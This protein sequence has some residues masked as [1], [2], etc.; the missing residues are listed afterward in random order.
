MEREHFFTCTN[1][2]GSS[3]FGGGKGLPSSPDHFLASDWETE[4]LNGHP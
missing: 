1:S 2:A 4:A 3:C